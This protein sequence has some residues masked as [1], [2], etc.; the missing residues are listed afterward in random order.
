MQLELF[1]PSVDQVPLEPITR[2]GRADHFRISLDATPRMTEFTNDQLRRQIQHHNDSSLYKMNLRIV[3]DCKG[4]FISDATFKYAHDLDCPK[5][6]DMIFVADE[7][8]STVQIE[9]QK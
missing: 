9:R 7:F 2:D 1:P 4:A 6:I 3:I 5:R 8:N